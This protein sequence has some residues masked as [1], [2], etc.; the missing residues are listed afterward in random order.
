MKTWDNLEVGDIL[1]N[2]VGFENEFFG[3]VGNLVYHN[4]K[5]IG[6]YLSVSTKEWLKENG[7]TIKQPGRWKPENKEL[8]WFLDRGG[9]IAGCYWDGDVGDLFRYSVGNVHKTKEEAEAYKQAL[10]EWGS[11]YG[12]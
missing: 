2:E 8:Y 5:G 1:V 3:V 9:S 10:L 6:G 7:W 12:V 4:T 11:K